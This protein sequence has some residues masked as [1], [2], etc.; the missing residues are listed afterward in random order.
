MGILKWL[1]GIFAL[2]ILFYGIGISINQIFLD[3][4]ER[5]RHFPC[6]YIQGMCTIKV[7]EANCSGGMPESQCERILNHKE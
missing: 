3:R 5:R 2:I 4:E 7:N 6:E 1:V